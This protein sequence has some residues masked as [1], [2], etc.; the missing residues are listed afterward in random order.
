MFDP[1]CRDEELGRAGRVRF[2][3]LGALTCPVRAIPDIKEDLAG[4]GTYQSLSLFYHRLDLFNVDPDI[5]QLGRDD[6]LVD[7]IDGAL[8]TLALVE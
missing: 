3:R 4:L 8:R 7:R 5:R 2:D 1:A 6:D